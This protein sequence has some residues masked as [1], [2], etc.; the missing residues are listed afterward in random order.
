MNG[1]GTMKIKERLRSLK[2]S[3]VEWEG[4]FPPGSEVAVVTKRGGHN[5]AMG[6]ERCGTNKINQSTTRGVGSPSYFLS[7]QITLEMIK[8]EGRTQKILGA[9]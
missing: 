2:S 9:L 5:R 8:M 3:Q 4:Q 7:F 1:G 6:R